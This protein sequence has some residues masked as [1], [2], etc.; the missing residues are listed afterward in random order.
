MQRFIR[1]STG[2]YPYYSQDI[3]TRHKDISFP[4]NIPPAVASKI[5]Y[6]LVEPTNQPQ[7]D[8][9]EEIQPVLVDGQWKQAWSSRDFTPQELMARLNRERDTLLAKGIEY[10]FPNGD[11]DHIQVSD[12]DMT[13]LLT[14][15]VRARA[16]LDDPEYRQRFRS[17][18]NKNYSLTAAEVVAMADHVFT[19]IQTWYETSWDVKD[20]LTQ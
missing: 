7:G 14:I 3:R 15:D 8:V 20:S 9:V 5:G 11:V 19:T 16:A 12:R 17:L 4:V 10:T 6:E 2:E 1:V 18:S 13:I